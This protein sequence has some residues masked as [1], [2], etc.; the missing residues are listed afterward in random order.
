[1][2]FWNPVCVGQDLCPK[3]EMGEGLRVVSWS[4]GED[5]SPLADTLLEFSTQGLVE[6]L[7]IL[8]I[9]PGAPRGGWADN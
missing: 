9:F 2:A 3:Q 7:L 8:L 1:M 5:H 4:A 6:L